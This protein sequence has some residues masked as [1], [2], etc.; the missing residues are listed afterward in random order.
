[1]T[2]FEAENNYRKI[3]KNEL[4]KRCKKNSQYSLRAFARDLELTSARLS[5]ILNN[6]RG[7]SRQKSEQIAK[8]LN[9]NEQECE[10]FCNLVESKHARSK[11]KRDLAQT[12]LSK[13]QRPEYLAIELC[14]FEVIANWY[15]LGIMQLLKLKNYKSNPQWMA[16]VLGIK[17]REAKEALDRL[18]K[19]GYI[20]KYRG[21]YTTADEFVSVMSAVPSQAIRN[22]HKQILQKAMNSID[23]QNMNLREIGANLF[24][25]NRSDLPKLKVMLGQ[26]RKQIDLEASKGIDRDSIYCVSTQLFEIGHYKL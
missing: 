16:H 6:K 23:E 5:E 22:F 25:L 24:T 3:L 26:L 17:E 12:R 11:I 15:H 7:L 10:Y 19:L 1:M 8:L 18:E 2:I 9:F 13:Y 21:R 4:E 14:H 20:K